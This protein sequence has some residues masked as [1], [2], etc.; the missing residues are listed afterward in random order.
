MLARMVLARFIASQLGNPRGAFGRHLMARLLNAGND[1][2]ISGTLAAIDTAPANEHPI[3]E[4]ADW[5]IENDPEPVNAMS[6]TMCRGG[7]TP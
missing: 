5:V 7:D 3:S 2:L 6:V 4:I 1:E